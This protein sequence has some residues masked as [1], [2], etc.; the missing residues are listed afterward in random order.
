MSWALVGSV[1]SML[2]VGLV[3]R[4]QVSSPIL[5]NMFLAIINDTY[6][7]VKE[8]LAGQND[9][10]QLSDL[11]KQVSSDSGFSSC[12]S[13]SGSGFKV[14]FSG[15]FLTGKWPYTLVCLWYP[16]EPGMM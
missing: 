16:W 12:T 14:L 13:T 11:L 1:G 3:V 15:L 2:L 5:Q 9:E 7:E 8:E 6:S 4:T 10:L